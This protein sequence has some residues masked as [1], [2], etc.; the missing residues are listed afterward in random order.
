MTATEEPED[1][2]NSPVPPRSL[3]QRL[4]PLMLV[5]GV[6]AAAAVFIPH[7]PR[8]RH[9]EL[10]VD[11]S[12]TVVGINVD[13]SATERGGPTSASPGE[14]MQGASWRFRAGTAPSTI[15]A[16]VRLP[17]GV[18]DVEILIER[19]DRTES[20]HRSITLGDADRIT[21]PVR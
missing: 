20:V 10:R 6:I 14:P 8:E 1:D 4:A 16:T 9:V 13:W 5:G 21:V 15:A 7:L 12:T 3:L 18:Y 17:D 11:D 19:T 2:A